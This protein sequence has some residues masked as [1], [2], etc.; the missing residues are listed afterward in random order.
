MATNFL[1]ASGTNGFIAAPTNLL[2]TELNTLA[3]GAA[4]TSSVAGPFSQST[5]SNAPWCSLYF[6]AGGAFT[7]VIGQC[8]YGWFLLSTDGGT[9]FETVV[10]TPSTTVLALSRNPDF[11]VPLDNAA[12]ASGNIRWCQGRFIKAPWESFKVVVQNIGGGSPVALPASGNLIK[13]GGIAIQ[14]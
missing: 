13:A 4:A 7:P 2:S 9:T 5:F 14:F 11:I 8:L 3:G 6:S 1:D 12:Y 10:A